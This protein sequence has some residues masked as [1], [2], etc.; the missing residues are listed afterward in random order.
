LTSYK[1]EEG[2]GVNKMLVS[3]TIKINQNAKK[4]GCKLGNV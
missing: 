4:S 2:I 3:S 1:D